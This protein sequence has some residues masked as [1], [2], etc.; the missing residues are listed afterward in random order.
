M[1]LGTAQEQVHDIGNG[2]MVLTPINGQVATQKLVGPCRRKPLSFCLRH[3]QNRHQFTSLPMGDIQ[4]A[5]IAGLNF[6]QSVWQRRGNKSIGLPSDN[7][8]VVTDQ[9]AAEG[10]DTNGNITLAGSGGSGNQQA[11]VIDC[12]NCPRDNL[13]AAIRTVIQVSNWKSDPN[14]RRKYQP[15]PD[16]S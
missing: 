5:E 1:D 15:D 16:Q 13:L 3:V 9:G 14:L 12:D 8:L 4:D 7:N 2:S 11:P 6:S 10:D